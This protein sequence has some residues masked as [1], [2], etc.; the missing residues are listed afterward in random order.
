LLP[1]DVS[2]IAPPAVLIWI[3]RVVPSEGLPAAA[4]CRVPASSVTWLPVAG[5]VPRLL[6]K[7]IARTLSNAPLLSVPPLTVQFVPVPPPV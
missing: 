5:A 7:L 2:V 4:I 1:P 3:L 6:P